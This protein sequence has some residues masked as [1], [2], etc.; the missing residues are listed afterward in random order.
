MA[1][2]HPFVIICWLGWFNQVQWETA[3]A[4]DY[5]VQSAL[6]EPSWHTAATVTIN[7]PG[8]VQ[9]LFPEHFARCL[10]PKWP[11]D[12]LVMG[13][14][15]RNFHSSA[16][17]HWVEVETP[18]TFEW[19]DIFAIL[20]PDSRYVRILCQ[21]R[22][23]PWGCSILELQVFP[24][25]A[26]LFHPVDGGTSRACRGSSRSDNSPSHY[27]VLQQNTLK[28][29]DRW[30]DVFQNSGSANRV[31]CKGLHLTCDQCDHLKARYGC[32]QVARK[33]VR[34]P[35]VA[36]EWN[37]AGG[38]A[39][40][41]RVLEELNL[42]WCCRGSPASIS[43]DLVTSRPSLFSIVDL[44]VITVTTCDNYERWMVW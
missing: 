20:C 35:P 24:A 30:V 33:S 14:G 25:F 41:G 17:L 42:L 26:G 18:E 37:T 39:K 10:G 9:T 13:L 11:C 31:K 12:G 43:C 4:R 1:N 34:W 29:E 40:F 3:Y 2:Q 6:D 16:S 38:D 27:T 8:E 22:A 44:G 19:I 15:T 32:R 5:L 28:G 23:T 36:W 7:E 21:T